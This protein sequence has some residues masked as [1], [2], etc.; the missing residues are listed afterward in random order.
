[1]AESQ[2]DRREGQEIGTD[3]APVDPPTGP[4]PEDAAN[5]MLLAGRI[6]RVNAASRGMAPRRFTCLCGQEV[7]EKKYNNGF[8]HC[9]KL[10][11]TGH[12]EVMLCESCGL[13]LVTCLDRKLA[14]ESGG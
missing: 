5:A 9:A 12:P 7:V 6:G 2:D 10:W 8:P 1:M 3:R 4:A 11:V 14:A 13:F